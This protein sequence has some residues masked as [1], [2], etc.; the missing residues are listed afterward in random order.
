[1][2]PKMIEIL[3]MTVT[4]EEIVLACINYDSEAHYS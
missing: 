3:R 1:M 4:I 2:L